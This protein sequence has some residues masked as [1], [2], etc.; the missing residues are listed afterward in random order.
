MQASKSGNSQK[1]Q[2]LLL[3]AVFLIGGAT[4]MIDV[5][6][7]GGNDSASAPAEALSV[8][9]QVGPTKP[10]AYACAFPD[11]ARRSVAYVQAGQQDK[12]AALF[13]SSECRELPRDQ[14]LAVVMV[15]DGY[16][17]VRGTDKFF[18][19][20]AWAPPG[21]LYVVNQEQDQ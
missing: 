13:D 4:M 12:F 20:G 21:M 6:G 2:M 10:G 9:V 8:G 16:V 1:W 17:L 15:T 3:L 19:K 18:D 11:T 14:D 7:V 5:L